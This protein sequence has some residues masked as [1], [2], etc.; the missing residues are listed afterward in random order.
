[1]DNPKIFYKNGL[2]TS[3]SLVEEISKK[4]SIDLAIYLPTYICTYKS[5][6]VCVCVHI[7]WKPGKK[8]KIPRKPKM[9]WKREINHRLSK[10]YL[11]WKQ[12]LWVVN[13]GFETDWVTGDRAQNS[14]RV[15]SLIENPGAKLDPPKSIA[16]SQYK[17]KLE[18]SLCPQRHQELPPQHLFWV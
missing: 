15:G 13:L 8:I 3:N 9:K 17:G 1:M 6:R 12:V 2:V 14:P 16:P 4:V 10:P 5:A 18:K 7:E 11:F